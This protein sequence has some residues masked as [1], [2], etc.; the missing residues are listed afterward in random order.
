ME[1]TPL[2]RSID[3]LESALEAAGTSGDKGMYSAIAL[4]LHE[5]KQIG[6]ISGPTY[7]VVIETMYCGKVWEFHLHND[8]IFKSSQQAE[9]LRKQMAMK[10]KK[11]NYKVKPV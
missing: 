3:S 9:E 2:E 1:K 11:I 6:L 5:I 7:R 10:A 4:R 8:P